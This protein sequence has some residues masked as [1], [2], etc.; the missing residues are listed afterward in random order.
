MVV[1]VI[2]VLMGS[3][4]TVSLTSSLD[5]SRLRTGART[6]TALCRYARSYA[7]AHRTMVRVRIDASARSLAVQL[8]ETESDEEDAWQPL[9]TPAGRLRTLPEGVQIVLEQENA[10]AG[11]DEA[12]VNMVFSPLGETD[13]I[14]LMLTNRADKRLLILLDGVTGRCEVRT[15][16]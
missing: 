11:T 12:T 15:A 5:D 4:V 13:N 8:K 1:L 9:T 2:M 3:I 10:A 16:E 14:A 7:V 6:V